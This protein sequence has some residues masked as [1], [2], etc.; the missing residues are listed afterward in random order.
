MKN[1]KPIIKNVF[2]IVEE[3]DVGGVPRYLI[4]VKEYPDEYFSILIE[5][6]YGTWGS[7]LSKEE[8]LTEMK[9]L[10][11]RFATVSFEKEKAEARKRLKQRHE[12]AQK[13][14]VIIAQTK[15]GEA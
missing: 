4:Q 8:A 15:E 13:E 1:V 12:Q 5:E 9:D 7:C 6:R 11:K 14:L 3:E 2:R 10:E